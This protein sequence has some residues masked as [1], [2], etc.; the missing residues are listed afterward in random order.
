MNT[1]HTLPCHFFKIHF[2]II[3]PFMPVFLM[4]SCL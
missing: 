3:L 2:N 4:V 1:V